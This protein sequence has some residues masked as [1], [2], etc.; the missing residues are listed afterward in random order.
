M[1]TD[2]ENAREICS[3]KGEGVLRIENYGRKE[4]LPFIVGVYYD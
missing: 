4:L 3:A 2:L 1:A